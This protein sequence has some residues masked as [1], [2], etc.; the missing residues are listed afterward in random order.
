LKEELKDVKREPRDLKR[1]M[2]EKIESCRSSCYG[3]VLD[4]LAGRKI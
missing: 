3:G 4:Q 2:R 1:Q